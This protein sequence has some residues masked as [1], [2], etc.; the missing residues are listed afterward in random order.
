VLNNGFDG[1][2]YPGGDG[3]SLFNYSSPTSNQAVQT[4]ILKATAAD[5]NETALENAVI[6]IAAWTDERGF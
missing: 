2:N 4:A 6:Q 5:L 1:T 3:V